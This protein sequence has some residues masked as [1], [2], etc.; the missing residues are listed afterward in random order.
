M[1]GHKRLEQMKWLLKAE[2]VDG[3]TAVSHEKVISHFLHVTYP[4]AARPS[5]NNKLLIT[6]VVRLGSLCAADVPT[7]YPVSFTRSPAVMLVNKWVLTI[8]SLARGEEIVQSN[9]ACGPTRDPSTN[10]KPFQDVV[11]NNNT[12]EKTL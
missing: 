4:S 10:P 9:S 3:K 5:I 8:N 1:R 6:C 11:K 12:I 7:K 2:Q